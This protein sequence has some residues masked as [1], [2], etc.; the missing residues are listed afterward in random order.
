M[1]TVIL[2]AGMGTRLGAHTQGNPKSLLNI[3]GST[4]LERSLTNLGDA[5]IRDAVI[6]LGFRG[7]AIIELIGN[8]YKGIDITYVENPEYENT[9]NMYSLAQAKDILKS[10]TEPPREYRRLISLSQAA[11]ANSCSC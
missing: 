6:V 7:E 4:L 10:D 3:D 2:A 8:K 11:L 9:G 1:K 5:G